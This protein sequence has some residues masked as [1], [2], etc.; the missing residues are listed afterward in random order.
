MRTAICLFTRNLRVHDNPV[1]RHAARAD[2]VVPVFVFD[3]GVIRSDYMRPNRTAF[4]LD[5][6][7]DL[8]HALSELGAGL[9]VRTGNPAAEVTR[10]AD[11]VD[12]SEVHIAADVTGFAH[13]RE[14]SLRKALDARDRTLVVHDAVVTAHAPGHLVP[15]GNDHFAV[16]SP[17]FR[18][19]AE[20]PLRRTVDVPESLRM[21]KVRVGKL[22]SRSELCPGETSPDIA[23]GG[24]S[25]ARELVDEWFD[26]G[27][28]GYDSGNDDL[29]ADATSRLS[30]YLHFGCLSPVELVERAG[31]SE[32]ERAFV[33][34]LAWRDFHHQVLAARPRAAQHDYRPRGDRW[35]ED[36]ESFRAWCEGRTGIPIV[37]AGMRQLARE[38]WMHN[39]TRMITSSFLTK[40]LG[41]DWR[42]GAR[43]FLDLLVD[44]D[45]ANNNMNWQWTAGTGTDTRPYRVL[46]P[47]RQAERYDP[48]GDYVRRYVPELKELPAKALHDPRRIDPEDLER[49]GYPAPLVDVDAANARFRAAKVGTSR[50]S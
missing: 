16:F 31:N 46:N 1:L 43:Y 6:L 40:T 42:L 50:V 22:P 24:E 10:L 29:A 8:K 4:L 45:I 18:R 28:A 38:G 7:R 19:W 12:A 23:K 15:T 26:D 41:I 27:I 17:Y 32:P 33:R 3:E 34:Q 2:R 48:N 13:A 9:V 37:D 35:R 47:I 44:G 25:R 20:T 36:E 5:C 11:E 14:D 49:L 39:R 30:P 21:P